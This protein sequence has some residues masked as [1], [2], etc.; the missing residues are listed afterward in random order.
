VKHIMSPSSRSTLSG[1]RE[2]DV[3]SNAV[4]LRLDKVFRIKD[5]LFEI[6]NDTKV[7]RGTVSVEPNADGW[8]EL[9][10]GSYEVVME[11]VI[12][13]ADGESGFVITRSTLNRNGV[14]LTSGLYDSG[15]GI[16]VNTGE[17]VGGVMA[18][19]MHVNIGSALIKKGTRVGQYVMWNAETLSLYNGSY[20]NHKEHDTK[21]Q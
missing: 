7:H 12:S 18:G 11:N 6:D 4:D 15:Y 5:S 2:E 14:F 3:Q 17:A 16:D 9:E 8:F 13:V 1:V 10:P 20:G 21:Y 19:V